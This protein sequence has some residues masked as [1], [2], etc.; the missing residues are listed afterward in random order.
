MTIGEHCFVGAHSNLA[1]NV[2]MG[3]GSR[4]D[5]MSLLAD[6][7]VIPPGAAL[8]GSPA[9]LLTCPCRATS[10]RDR[11]RRRFLFGLLHLGLIY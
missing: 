2:T 1:L 3:D 8:A 10:N 4:L 11:P 9:S 5:D 6:G 7:E